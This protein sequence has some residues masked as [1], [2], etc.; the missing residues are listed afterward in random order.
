MTGEKMS[1]N[2]DK[3]ERQETGGT[4]GEPS[5]SSLGEDVKARL[6][7]EHKGDV[8]GPNA[9]N[10]QVYQGS[11]QTEFDPQRHSFSKKGG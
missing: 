7:R 1:R 2:E 5:P 8:G 10:E 3:R 11:K 9:A 6:P 4:T